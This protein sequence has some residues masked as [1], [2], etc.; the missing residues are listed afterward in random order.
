MTIE[1]AKERVIQAARDWRTQL[2]HRETDDD[3]WEAEDDLIDA[4]IEL[5]DV[6]SDKPSPPAPADIM[7]IDALDRAEAAKDA[8]PADHIGDFNKMVPQVGELWSTVSDGNVIIRK[9]DTHTVDVAFP[10]E[11]DKHAGTMSRRHLVAMVS[12]PP[13]GDVCDDGLCAVCGKPAHPHNFRH[14]F[15]RKQKARE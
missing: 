4:L 1:Q 10:R 7:R 6:E 3:L 15:K 2:G 11:P 12:A 14:H 13:A 5:D 9:V 8:P